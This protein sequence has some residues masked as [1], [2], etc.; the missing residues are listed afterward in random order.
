MGGGGCLGERQEERGRGSERK[1]V[2]VLPGRGGRNLA[3]GGRDG[4]INLERKIVEKKHSVRR[5][6]TY[7]F[8]K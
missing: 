1:Y 7:F 3:R 2:N 8:R 4:L 6:N 5:K